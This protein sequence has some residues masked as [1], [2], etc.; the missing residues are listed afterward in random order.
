MTYTLIYENIS[1]YVNL[2]K[3]TC[4]KLWSDVF[5]KKIITNV[6]IKMRHLEPALVL[7]LCVF[8]ILY[9]YICMF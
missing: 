1:T 2:K 8:A 9:C 4:A 3:K 6:R 7:C 5:L